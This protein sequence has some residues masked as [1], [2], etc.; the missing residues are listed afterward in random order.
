MVLGDNLL[1]EDAYLLYH[2]QPHVLAFY[3][4][5]EVLSLQATAVGEVHLKIELYSSVCGVFVYRPP[6]SSETSYD[7][8]ST[9]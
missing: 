8:H 9:W 5:P 1:V 3:V 2:Q 7:I 4:E 6:L